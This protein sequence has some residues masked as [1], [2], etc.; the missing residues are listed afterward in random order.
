MKTTLY[1]IRHAAT[2]ANL[3]DPPRLQGRRHNPPLA[4]FGIQQAKLTRDF[5]GLRPIDVCY[6]SPMVRAMQTATIVAE[7]H[8]IMS[9]PVDELTEC[10]VG[11]WEG[12]DWGTI[13]GRDPEAHRRFMA[14]PAEF[15]YPGGENF[16]QVH[17]RALAA[18]EAILERE[19]GRSVLVV[20]HHIV[21]RTYL[22]GLLGMGPGQARAVSLD[23]CGISVVVR[24]GTKTAVT[25]L[26]ASFHLQGAAA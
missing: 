19:A 25:T 7:P 11:D 23:N 14:N 3:A 26:N 17:G 8:G 9:T 5:L 20:S 13:R 15:G 6:S 16:A 21:N 24:H 22:A 4:R 2:E 18:I 10:D 12:M 1:L